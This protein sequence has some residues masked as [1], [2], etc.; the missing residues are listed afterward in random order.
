MTLIILAPN[1][2]QNIID[3]NKYKEKIVGKTL[4]VDALY[5][6]ALEIEQDFNQNGFPL[7]RVILPTQELE[8]DQATIF[9]KVIDGF[10]EQVDLSK[11]PKNQVMR[12]F[13]YLKPLIRKKL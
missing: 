6:T 9:F 8:P 11:V 10:I 12:T 1:V 13:F 2:L 5:A 3:L 7:V 4:T